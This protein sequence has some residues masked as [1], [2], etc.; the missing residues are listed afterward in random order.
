LTI[1]AAGFM[2]QHALKAAVAL[3]RDNILAGVLDLRT[4]VPL[5]REGLA[6]E[7]AKTSAML[8]IDDDYADYG[9]CAEVIASVAEQLGGNAPRMARHAVGV[10]IPANLDLE[11]A[12]VPSAASIAIAARDILEATR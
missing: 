3:E 12:V 10:P 4:L 1:V 8:V 9:M 11:Q 6:R 5:D 7:A 2:V